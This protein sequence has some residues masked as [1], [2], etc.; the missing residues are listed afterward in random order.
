[1]P[2]HVLTDITT[3]TRDYV[4]LS[5][6]GATCSGTCWQSH[7]SCGGFPRSNGPPILPLVSRFDDGTASCDDVFFQFTTS[8]QM[9]V[10]VKG[11]LLS[12]ALMVLSLRHPRHHDILMVTFVPTASTS[13]LLERPYVHQGFAPPVLIEPILSAVFRRKAKRLEYGCNSLDTPG[14][15]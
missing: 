13:F 14:R 11:R 12:K 3:T 8:I 1:M 10:P 5:G 4:R 2:R 15:S 9:I 7:I 6:R